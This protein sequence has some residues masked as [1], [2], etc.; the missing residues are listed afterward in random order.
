VL[1]TRNPGKLRELRELLADLPVRVRSLDEFPPVEEPVEDGA[2]FAD[3]ARKKA[4]YYAAAT[5]QWCLA[6]DS[7][8][9]V[10]ALGQAPGVHSARFA[11]D[12]CP[13]GAPR[14]AIDAANN[15]KLLEL[16]RNVPQPRSARFICHVALAGEGRILIESDGRIEGVIIDEPAGENG[17]GYDPLFYVPSLGCTTAQLPAQRKNQVS[18]RGNALREFKQALAAM[19]AT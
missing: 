16:L 2:T 19:L 3:N 1:A 8:L 18:H 17:F 12:R 13:P 4:M 11:A 14:H 10:D 5:G 9:A 7:G 6:D 15:A